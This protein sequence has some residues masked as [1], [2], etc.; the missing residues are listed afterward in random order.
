M[1]LNQ[2]Y[3]L[4]NRMKIKLNCS[5]PRD[6]RCR[7]RLCGVLLCL[8][9][10]GAPWLVPAVAVEVPAPGQLLLSL[11]VN[12]DHGLRILAP[13]LLELELDQVKSPDTVTLSVWNFAS[14]GSALLT[15]A[16]PQFTVLA[17]GTALPVEAFGFKRRVA[18]APLAHRDLRVA[19]YLYLKLAG[20]V[21]DNQNVEVRNPDG[22]LWPST[23]VFTARKD[24]LRFNPA[25]HVNQEGYLPA[26]PKKAM[27]GYYLGS[28]GEMSVPAAAGFKLVDASGTE[29]FSGSLRARPDVGYTYSPAPYQAVYEA[30]F[31]GF[32]TPGVYRLV[33]PGMGASLSF[34]ID[35][36]E[37]M[38]FARAYALGLYHQRCGAPNEL[39]F[40]RFTHAACHT[41]PAAVP[42]PQ[43]AF[44]F[45][46]NIVA[47]VSSDFAANPRHTA[48]QLRSEATQL[49]PLVNTGQIDVSGGHHDAGDYSKYTT[50]SAALVHTLVFAVDALPGVADLD[51]LGL[52]E[53]GDG[54]SDLLQEAKWEADFLAKLQDA[55]GGFYFLVYPRDRAYENN[56]LPDRGDP[57]V[58]WPKNTA[59]TAAATAALAQA[60][61]SP[62]FKQTYPEA[63]AL[64][65]QKARLGW[66]FLTNAI[67][68]YGKD[69]AYQKL[70]HYG[71][72]FMHDD[73][74]AW[75]ATELFLA[76]GDEAYHQKLK[77]WFDPADPVTRRWGWW[78]MSESYGNAIRS[79]AFAA[80]SGR[81][82]ASRLDATFLLK[83]EQQ[84]EGAGRDA[85]QWSDQSAYGTS[86][87]EETKHVRGGGWYFSLDQ[88][89]DLIV[90]DQLD[91]PPANDPRPRF[92]EAYLTNMNYEAGCNP[93]NISYITGLGRRRQR[94]I[95]HQYA[96]NDRRV[97]P[98]SGLP[99][100]NL[101]TG[102]PY[103]DLY[104]S[105]LGAMSYPD[106]GAAVAP[107]PYYDRWS[108]TFNV[109]TEFVVV[110][111]ARALAGLAFLAAQTPLRNQSW[112]PVAAQIAGLPA[113][114]PINT[115]VTVTFQGPPDWDAAASTIVWEAQDQEP[116]SGPSFTFTPGA[117]GTQWVEVEA[118]Q[119]DG[120][121]VFAANTF[122]ADNGLPNVT[123]TS[124]AT[125]ASVADNTTGTF[126]FHRTGDLAGALN[127]NFDLTGT[128]TKW[129]DYRRPEGDMPDNVTFPAG[130]DAVSLTIVPVASSLLDQTRVV[131]LAVKSGSTYNAGSPNTVSITLAGASASAPPPTDTPPPVTSS[132]PPV[133]NP[134]PVTSPPPADNSPP[135]VSDPPPVTS[136]PPNSTPPPVSEPPPVVTPPPVTAPPPP[137]VTNPPPVTA[138]SPPARPV[139]NGSGGALSDWF[140]AALAWLCLLRWR[141]RRS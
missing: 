90:A 38:N 73:E 27:V 86:F 60:A 96:Q 23:T 24:P 110:N 54:I 15:L 7:L 10:L 55:D 68:K 44:S 64:Y 80:R 119:P 31:S 12:N 70:T 62:R 59:A 11:P 105:E 45:T 115:P 74:L 136:P 57:Q 102:L 121:R 26:S 85:L 137:P 25:L 5:P 106:D 71:D 111:Q 65:L 109:S 18:Y 29:V 94:E 2:E 1:A 19:S 72:N 9:A 37:A 4:G 123:V 28:L 126:N 95:V 81:L 131:T 13:N 97:L 42:S 108:D 125:L 34:R 138:P 14:S 139:R 99:L 67:T 88:A 63:A 77:E 32:T 89:F 133:T 3:C 112:R 93:V 104:T 30:D 50:N 101:Q 122:G 43:S 76:T 22:Q 92:I 78:R 75:A 52:P 127:I 53:S 140:L 40:T 132:P 21:A 39:P 128:A 113:Q 33:V 118:Y 51:N 56:V 36:G 124:P 35:D 98:P 100:G 6:G 83:C 84:I 8:L 120:R 141:G 107:Y 58:V 41:A 79:Y 116:A 114:A 49:Y 16:L 129:N 46:W 103:L 117:N 47:Q 82:P 87:P 69:G 91:Y 134:P 17:D 66:Q 61:S 130:A 20:D 135:P 48:P